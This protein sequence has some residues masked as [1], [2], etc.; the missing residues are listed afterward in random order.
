MRLN[1]LKNTQTGTLC[2]LGRKRILGFNGGFKGNVWQQLLSYKVL[3]QN[4]FIIRWFYEIQESSIKISH[5]GRIIS[6]CLLTLIYSSCVCVCSFTPQRPLS[7]LSP[8][9]SSLF[10][11][12]PPSLHQLPEEL[13]VWIAALS[14][15]PV[16]LRDAFWSAVDTD[17]PVRWDDSR[18]WRRAQ[19]GTCN[20]TRLLHPSATTPSRFPSTPPPEK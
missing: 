9:D 12:L 17:R 15:Q 14:V 18:K 7:C 10:S 5:A 20:V 3:S 16:R 2:F 6:G 4:Y 1:L 13:S 19:T 8:P 11:S